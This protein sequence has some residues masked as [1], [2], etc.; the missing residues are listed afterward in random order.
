MNRKPKKPRAPARPCAAAMKACEDYLGLALIERTVKESVPMRTKWHQ[1]EQRPVS[2]IEAPTIAGLAIDIDSAGAGWVRFP[3]NADG[4][5]AIIYRV[6][7]AADFNGL[8]EPIKTGLWRHSDLL[9]V[10]PAAPIMPA[11]LA[12]WRPYRRLRLP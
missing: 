6:G 7:M 3:N 5:C 8:P 12:L 2:S 1:L 11:V 10:N 9:E 4:N